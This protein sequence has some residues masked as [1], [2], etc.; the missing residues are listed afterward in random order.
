[1]DWRTLP[2][3]DLERKGKMTQMEI[4]KGEN[5]KE[6]LPRK[7]PVPPIDQKSF[8]SNKIQNALRKKLKVS[9]V[10]V[11]LNNLVFMVPTL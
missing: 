11:E 9:S 5:V 6:V 8:L 1:M 7:V 2:S 3:S 4:P 10:K